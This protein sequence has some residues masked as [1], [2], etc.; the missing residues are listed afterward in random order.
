[1]LPPSSRYERLEW[2]L[3]S[4]SYV[5]TT[6]CPVSARLY[7]VMYLPDQTVSCV[8]WTTQC[9]VSAGLYSIM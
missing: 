7:S 1:M 5:P 8:F 2:V 4:H 3:I 6:Q 9:H